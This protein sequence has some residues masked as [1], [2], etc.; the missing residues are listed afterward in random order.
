MTMPPNGEEP[1]CQYERLPKWFLQLVGKVEEADDWVC[2]NP[3]LIKR[4]LDSLDYA[5]QKD[6]VGCLVDMVDE[7]KHDTSHP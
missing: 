3:G 5:Q 2:K 1:V 6:L 4:V 7:L